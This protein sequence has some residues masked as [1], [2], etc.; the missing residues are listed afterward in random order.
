M[1]QYTPMEPDFVRRHVEHLNTE[2]TDSR[3]TLTARLA[4]GCWPGGPEDRGRPAAISWIRRWHP[5]RTVASLPVC[6]CRDG[7][8]AICN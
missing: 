4:A 6:T 7:R 8:C 2:G 5:A 3:L 1:S